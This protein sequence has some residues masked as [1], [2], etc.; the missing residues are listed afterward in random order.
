MGMASVPSIG[1]GAPFPMKKG[2]TW[3]LWGPRRSTQ[4]ALLCGTVTWETQVCLNGD[5]TEA[6]LLF[7]LHARGAEKSRPLTAQNLLQK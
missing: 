1:A 7:D 4:L 6:W 3:R 2:C 5:P